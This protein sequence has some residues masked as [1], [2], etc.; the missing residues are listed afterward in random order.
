MHGSGGEPS[1]TKPTMKPDQNWS[2]MPVLM[3]YSERSMLA[4]FRS[5]S[6]ASAVIVRSALP[7]VN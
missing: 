7:N 3:W 4:N 1:E 6:F 5:V 2:R